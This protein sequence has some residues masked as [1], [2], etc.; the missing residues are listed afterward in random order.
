MKMFYRLYI[1]LF[2][3]PD[4]FEELRRGKLQYPPKVAPDF[5]LS[6]MFDNIEGET[7]KQDLYVVEFTFSFFTLLNFCFYPTKLLSLLVPLL[8]LISHYFLIIWHLYS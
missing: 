5:D 3:F 8:F 1:Y 6:N 4:S 2:F 7:S